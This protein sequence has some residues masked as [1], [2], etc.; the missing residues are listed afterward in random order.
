MTMFKQET[1]EVDLTPQLGRKQHMAEGK[2][3]YLDV[4]IQIRRQD[5][6]QEFGKFS[7]SGGTHL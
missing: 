6:F 7:G 1:A 2:Q 3:L 4:C 5:L